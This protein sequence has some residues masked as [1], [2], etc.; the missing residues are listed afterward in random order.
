M[1]RFKVEVER[2]LPV[3]TAAFALLVERTLA[4]PRGWGHKGRLSFQR[5][6]SGAVAFTVVL[7]SPATTD[8]LCRPL[9][10]GGVFSCYNSRGRAVINY[11]RW[12]EGAR[13]YSGH[14]AQYRQYVIS[15]EVGHALGHGHLYGCRGDGRAPTMMQQTKS[16]YGCTRNPWPYPGA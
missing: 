2:G 13:S 15:H 6:S 4:D 1:R 16:L 10:T 8:R 5:V 3:D 9:R 11:R 14:L 7:A 12:T